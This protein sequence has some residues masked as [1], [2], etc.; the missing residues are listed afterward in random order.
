MPNGLLVVNA[1]LKLPKFDAIYQELLQ[2]AAKL[3]LRLTLQTNATIATHID[4]P[5][6]KRALPDFVLFWDKDIKTARLLEMQGIPVFNS[7]ESIELCDDKALTYLALRRANIAVPRTVLLPKTF[8]NIGYTDTEFL[9]DAAD[10]LSYPL[11]LKECFGSFGQQVYL[12]QNQEELAAKVLSLAGTPMLLQELVAESYGRDTRINIVG[13]KVVASILRESQNGDFR[14]N[15]TLG[16][17]MANYTPTD[18]E[19]E[20]ALRAVRALGLTFAGVDVLFGK[21]GPLICEVNSNAHFQTTLECTGVNMA[22]AIL[23]EIAQ[24][25]G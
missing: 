1:F 5:A 3:N 6:F 17:S 23:R 11:V 25:I 19:S 4:T 14:S 7:A 13:G 24:R 16:G 9:A 10:M 18:R 2:S 20:L 8:P 12:I 22:D 15:L 21:N